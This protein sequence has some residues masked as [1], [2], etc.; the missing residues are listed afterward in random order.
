MVFELNTVILQDEP[1]PPKLAV[2]THVAK[3]IL[4]VGRT[5]SSPP[6]PV[7]GSHALTAVRNE[8]IE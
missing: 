4:R 2:T 6:R 8:V 3:P 5:G 7:R 1:G